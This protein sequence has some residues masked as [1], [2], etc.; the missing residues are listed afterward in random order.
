MTLFRKKYYTTS[1]R[2]K[3]KLYK[4]VLHF[5]FEVDAYF[6]KEEL[7]NYNDDLRRLLNYVLKI[8]E[9][10]QKL[11]FKVEKIIEIEI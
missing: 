3:E 7:K 6:L 4:L 1:F 2:R 10:K 11:P 5:P 8:E 9:I